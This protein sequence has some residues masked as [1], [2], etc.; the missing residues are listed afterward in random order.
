MMRSLYQLRLARSELVSH[1]H[2]QEARV[3]DD[4][5]KSPDSN[6]D[7]RVPDGLGSIVNHSPPSPKCIHMVSVSPN[8]SDFAGLP[9]SPSH[10]RDHTESFSSHSSPH[11][12]FNSPSHETLNDAQASPNDGHTVMPHVHHPVHIHPSSAILDLE[13]QVM[14][15]AA[16]VD[17]FKEERE[18]LARVLA[19]ERQVWRL[20]YS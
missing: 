9:F 16:K 10:P 18:L 6:L 7:D 8:L 14:A 11:V 17:A 4:H 5:E 3:A 2:V 12:A 20:A 13:R 19:E 1:A 15:L